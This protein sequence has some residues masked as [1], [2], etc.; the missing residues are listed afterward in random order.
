MQPSCHGRAVVGYS[1][2]RGESTFGREV[3][4]AQ[5]AGRRF[6]HHRSGQRR[7]HHRRQHHCVNGQ[8]FNQLVTGLTRFDFILLDAEPVSI[9]VTVTSPNGSGSLI[10]ASGT[11]LLP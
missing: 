8:S 9:T 2:G 1:E 10:V 6:G 3:R 4:A 7:H 5:P 11:I